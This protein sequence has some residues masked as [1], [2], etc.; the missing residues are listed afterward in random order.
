MAERR[1]TDRR[2]SERSRGE[3]LSATFDLAAEVGY[4]ALTIEGVATRAGVGK[5]TI[6]RWWP[7]KG[8]VLLDALL[9]R[10]LIA[11]PVPD[12]GDLRADLEAHMTELG[13]RLG[14]PQMGAYRGLIAA[15]QSDPDL[16]AAIERTLLRPRVEACRE[17]LAAAEAAGVLRPD[18][19]VDQLIEVLYAPMYYRFVL[20][21]RP[22]DGGHAAA[23]LDLVLPAVMAET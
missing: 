23:V 2:R 20:Q 3:I 5:Q 14:E 8:A 19:D 16:A 1:T 10:A 15:G 13:R 7:S 9:D 12:T 4:A 18:V 6:Y 21:D 11:L 17:R 22:I